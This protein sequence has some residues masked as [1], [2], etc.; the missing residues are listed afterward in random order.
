MGRTREEHFE[1]EGSRR[2]G[3]SPDV[4]KNQ[5]AYDRAARKTGKG[6][7]GAE[8]GHVGWAGSPGLSSTLSSLG[9]H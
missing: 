5:R 4:T 1:E 3:H 7:G 2:H 8:D 6:S 9:S